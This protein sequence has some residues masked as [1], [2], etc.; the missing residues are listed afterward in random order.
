MSRFNTGNP[1]GS[2]DPR[3]LDDNAKNMDLAV[4]SEELSWRDRFGRDRKSF[5]G[6]EREFD[7]AQDSRESEFDAGQAV[8]ENEFESAQNSREVRFNDFIVSSGYQFLGDYAAGIE[9]TEY[10]QLVRDENGEF[11]RVSGQ[12]DLPYVTTGAGI[13]EDDA[14][15][16]AG[17]AVLRQDLANPGL[18][19]G[20]VGFRHNSGMS[21][22]Q[23]VQDRIRQLPLTP[24]DVVSGPSTTISAAQLQDVLNT[25]D[26]YLPAGYEWE[27][28]GD[29]YLPFGRKI[30]GGGSNSALRFKS[31]GLILEANGGKEFT[32]ADFTILLSGTEQI[33]LDIRGDGVGPSPTRWYISN[34]QVRSVTPTPSNVGIHIQGG[35]IGSIFNP[36]VRNCGIGVEIEKSP[37]GPGVSFN[38]LAFFG[39][40]IQGNDTGVHA[41]G[42]LGLKFFGTAIEGNRQ[43]G[44]FLQNTCRSVLFSGVYFEANGLS[45]SD[46]YNDVHIAAA[47][48]TSVSNGIKFDNC[49]FLRG[50]V[51]S[52]TAIDAT[53]CLGLV[54][55]ETCSFNGYYYR[56][57]VDEIASGQTT[58]RFAAIAPS[59]QIPIENNTTRFG[60]PKLRSYSIP[61]GFSM[62]GTLRTDYEYFPISVPASSANTGLIELFIVSPA[63]GNV[64]LAFAYHDALTG[65]AIGPVSSVVRTVAAGMNLVTIAPA[66]S[67]RKGY[68]FLLE[69]SRLGN[70]SADTLEADI[71]LH[72]VNFTVYA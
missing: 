58:G 56:L 17:D 57:K 59:V 61:G 60:E 45:D 62:S 68:D 11:W 16:P 46:V 35:W 32:L 13:P 20:L 25:G 6:M 65:G 48:S 63:A 1:L 37:G 50:G 14:L 72:A 47:G 41:T 36:I 55:D 70:N 42:V 8:R 23:T 7:E 51:G 64:V 26:L 30:T 67:G 18:G 69:V 24:F 4:N 19:A 21:T 27:V 52:K 12:V 3:D 33:G 34:L 53:N 29:V 44:A 38:Q 49:S 15:V 54:V 39:G 66:L 71:L 22:G 10:N 43:H 31:G 2:G 28:D 9:F 5:E 40:E